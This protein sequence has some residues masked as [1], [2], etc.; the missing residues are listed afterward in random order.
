MSGGRDLQRCG[1]VRAGALSELVL[2]RDRDAKPD[3][4][5][6]RTPV[7]DALAESTPPSPT[8]TP[9]PSRADLATVV[10]GVSATRTPS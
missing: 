1:R 3:E 7:I 10:Y 6:F 9:T 4:V 2:F 5:L 8:P